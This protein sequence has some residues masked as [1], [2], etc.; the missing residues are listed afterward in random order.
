MNIAVNDPLRFWV[1]PDDG[2]PYEV[3]LVEFAKGGRIE[4]FADRHQG[5][6]KGDYQGR[7]ALAHEIAEYFRDLASH[8]GRQREYQGDIP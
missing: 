3:D 2:P 8:E 6:W 7:K 5:Q 4:D 1:R